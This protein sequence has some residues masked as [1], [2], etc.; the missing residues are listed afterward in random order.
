MDRGTSPILT[1]KTGI[2]PEEKTT[3]VLTFIESSKHFNSC[4]KGTKK[5]AL[6]HFITMPLALNPSHRWLL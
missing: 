2:T 5:T 4:E 3:K 1:D 6:S